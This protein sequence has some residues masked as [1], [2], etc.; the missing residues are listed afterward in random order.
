MSKEVNDTISSS[1]KNIKKNT[2]TAKIL[3]FLLFLTIF[4]NG[5]EAGGYQ[6]SLLSI[7]TGYQLGDAAMGIFA[8]VQLIAGLIAPLVFGPIADRSGKKK[9]F[10]I[11]LCVQLAG[12]LILLL[13][14]NAQSFLPGIF[15]I[16]LSVSALQYIALAQLAD[17]FPQ[18]GKKKIGII[19]GFYSLGAVAAPTICGFYLGRGFSWKLLFL[20]LL[21]TTAVNAAVSFSTD[22]SAQEEKREAPMRENSEMESAQSGKMLLAGVIFLCIIMFVYVGFENGF[23]FFINSYISRELGGSHAYLALSLFWLAMIPSRILCGYFSAYNRQILLLSSAGVVLFTVLICIVPSEVPALLVSL[24]LGFFSGAIYP[25]VLARSM[26]FANG[27]TATVTGLITASTGLGGAIV[28]ALTGSVSQNAGI[29]T[30]LMGLAL[31]M[32]VDVVVS[33][34]LI[35]YPLKTQK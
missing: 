9:I 8:S 20:I 24:P 31:F 23:A 7:G 12:C 34:I 11:F 16:G 3:L 28:S 26:D 29:R 30:A 17:A 27:R 25:S 6:A 2:K 19:T 4:M 32:A 21:I 15:V 13:S 10:L 1:S 5:F 14:Q 35:R 33:L 22:F 18:T